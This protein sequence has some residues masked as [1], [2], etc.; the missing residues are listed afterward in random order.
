MQRICVLRWWINSIHLDDIDFKSK[1]LLCAVNQQP[2][3]VIPVDPNF[4]K[5]PLTGSMWTCYLNH[6]KKRLTNQFAIHRYYALFPLSCR[7]TWH[8]KKGAS[9]PNERC[10]INWQTR[11]MSIFYCAITCTCAQAWLAQKPAQDSHMR[12]A[13]IFKHV[14]ARSWVTCWFGY[15]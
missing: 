7:C 1:L 4:C 3:D 6:G 13:F 10:Y 5:M 2:Y 9:M 11:S 14:F 12:A 15:S 8:A